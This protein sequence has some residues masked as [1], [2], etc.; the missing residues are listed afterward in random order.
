MVCT[1]SAHY[2]CVLCSRLVVC[3]VGALPA[4][5]AESREEEE[6]EGISLSLC[7]RGRGL[8]RHAPARMANKLPECS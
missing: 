3:A 2:F 7:T 1:F 4:K 8:T 6:E 5:G